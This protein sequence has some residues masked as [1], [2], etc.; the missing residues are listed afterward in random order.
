MVTS[1]AL[2]P[3]TRNRDLAFVVGGSAR[4]ASGRIL[5]FS[6]FLFCRRNLSDDRASASLPVRIG[7]VALGIPGRRPISKAVPVFL[8]QKKNSTSR[9]VSVGL[10][11]RRPNPS[12]TVHSRTCRATAARSGTCGCRGHAPSAGLHRSRCRSKARALECSLRQKTYTKNAVSHA[13]A[14]DLPT[15][16]RIIF[17]QI[18]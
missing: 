11:A 18:L 12:S 2:P 15:H 4:A 3:G 14:G 6:E 7:R 13:D 10:K 1:K 8:R 9:S 5:L 16:P 17:Y